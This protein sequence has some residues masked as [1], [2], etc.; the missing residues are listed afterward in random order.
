MKPNADE[1]CLALSA[2]YRVLVISLFEKGALDV[3]VFAEQSDRA[4][5]R[6]SALNET[7]A[8]H[9]LAD[10]LEPLIGDL[11]RVQAMRAGDGG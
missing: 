3:D 2:A 8:S 6:Y 9:V 10:L 1:K 11:R 7:V 4:I 5:A